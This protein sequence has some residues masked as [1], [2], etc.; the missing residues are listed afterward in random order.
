MTKRARTGWSA[1]ALVLTLVAGV[2]GASAWVDAGVT[3][4]G[5]FNTGSVSWNDVGETP[6]GASLSGRIAISGRTTQMFTT[7]NRGFLGLT[8]EA[9][10]FWSCSNGDQNAFLQNFTTSS[11]ST[12]KFTITCPSGTLA[13]Q[14]AG[15]IDDL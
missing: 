4:S 12:P 9:A 8:H 11:S 3:P 7:H 13:G 10:L 2:S 1:A 14:A 6:F 5:F 15:I